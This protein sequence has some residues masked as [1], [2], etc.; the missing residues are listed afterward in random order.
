MGSLAAEVEYFQKKGDLCLESRTLQPAWLRESGE[1]V[2]ADR[3]FIWGKGARQPHINGSG[4][5]P[6]F[7]PNQKPIGRV[8]PSGLIK[9]E[10]DNPRK[11]IGGVIPFRRTK[12]GFLKPHEKR[13]QGCAFSGVKNNSSKA[14]Q[15]PVHGLNP[16]KKLEVHLLPFQQR[17]VR[18][19]NMKLKITKSITKNC[20]TRS[21]DLVN[22]VIA[23]FTQ[24]NPS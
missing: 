17:R 11:T 18:Q 7:H 15:Y 20:V 10:F 5:R 14:G 22:V 4:E 23:K 12:T 9:Q 13:C 6:T 8:R 2:D 1:A 19:N 24:V 16:W 3:V 21:L